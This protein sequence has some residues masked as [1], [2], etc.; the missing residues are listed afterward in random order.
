[1]SIRL[2]DRVQFKW[3]KKIVIRLD[4][5]DENITRHKTENVYKIIDIHRHR[6]NIYKLNFLLLNDIRLEEDDPATD[7]RFLQYHLLVFF[8]IK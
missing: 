7:S 4:F 3:N 2:N 1:M 6:K 5:L 8:F